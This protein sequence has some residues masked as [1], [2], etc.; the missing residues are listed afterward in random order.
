MISYEISPVIAVESLPNISL[1]SLT[2]KALKEEGKEDIIIYE[3]NFLYFLQ[4]IYQ[5][6]LT[7]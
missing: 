3:D 5:K 6:Y 4:R 1:Y 2:R 7:F